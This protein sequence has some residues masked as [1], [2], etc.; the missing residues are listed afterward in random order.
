MLLEKKRANFLNNRNMQKKYLTKKERL[1]F[2]LSQ[3]EREILIGLLL[4]DLCMTKKMEES[5]L[6]YGFHKV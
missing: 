2:S 6:C 3:K 4:G 1:E 5:I